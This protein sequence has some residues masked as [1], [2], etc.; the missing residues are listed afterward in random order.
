MI[1]TCCKT[2]LEEEK[3]KINK[4]WDINDLVNETLSLLELMPKQVDLEEKGSENIKALL[5]NL[6]S[7]PNYLA[8]LRNYYGSG[9]GKSKNFE[10]L[11]ERHAKLAVGASLTFVGFVWDTFKVIK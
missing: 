6:K 3:I 4:K 8:E 1:E 2:I 9:H 7:I 10:S 5:G 11:E